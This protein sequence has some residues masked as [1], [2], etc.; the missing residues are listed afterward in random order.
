MIDNYF[1]DTMDKTK[2]KLTE[3]FQIEEFHCPVEATLSLIGGKYKTLILWNLIGKT[4]RF[5]ELRRLIPSATPKMLT[6]Q[7]RE[8]EDAGLLC[9]KAG[10][11]MELPNPSG[12]GEKFLEKFR[13]GKADISALNRAVLRVLTAKFRMGLFEHPFSL[14]GE[15]LKGVFS[16]KTDR[17]VSLQSAKESLVLLKNNGVLPIGSAGQWNK[18]I[19]RYILRE[20]ENRGWR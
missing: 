3:E 18:K 1:L 12:F 7:L 16:Q 5:S 9:L 17:E 10:M 8:L 11:D 15:E 2:S 6:Q 14:Q 19:I 20:K 4:L 13:T